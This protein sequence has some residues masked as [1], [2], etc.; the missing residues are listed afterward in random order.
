MLS[1]ANV[2]IK[3]PTKWAAMAPNAQA[4]RPDCSSVMISTENVE[5][6]VKPPQN[7]VAMNKRHS[8]G[9]CGYRVKNA[10]AMPIT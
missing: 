9:I 10:R 8:G 2:S 5:K 6:V 4:V 3:E 1:P 7:P